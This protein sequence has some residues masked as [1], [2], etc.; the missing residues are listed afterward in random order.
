MSVAMFYYEDANNSSSSKLYPLSS[1]KGFMERWLPLAE[2]LGLENV[3]Q[4][5]MNIYV[6]YKEAP[7]IIDELERMKRFLSDKDPS[8]YGIDLM[9]LEKAI[10]VLKMVQSNPKSAVSIG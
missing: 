8:N 1:E 3:A 4:F 5:D 10:S 2:E 6:T 7:I 9:R